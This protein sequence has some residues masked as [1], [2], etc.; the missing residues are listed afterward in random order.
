M[1]IRARFPQAFDSAARA[2]YRFA[3]HASFFQICN[4]R[5]IEISGSSACF[6]PLLSHYDGSAS[7]AADEG[8]RSYIVL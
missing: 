2:P 7:S 8:S 3:L 1:K 5:E 4:V 6:K